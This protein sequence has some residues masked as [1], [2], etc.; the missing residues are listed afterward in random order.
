MEA[1]DDNM[2]EEEKLE[3]EEAPLVMDDGPEMADEAPQFM[4]IEDFE[5][6]IELISATQSVEECIDE[7]IR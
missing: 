2:E 5:R 1:E 6:Q 4:N 7:A 3:E